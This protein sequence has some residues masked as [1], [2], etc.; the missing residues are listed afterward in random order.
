MKELL[1]SV[2]LHNQDF[3]FSLAIVSFGTLWNLAVISLHRLLPIQTVHKFTL[4]HK[5]DH[6]DLRDWNHAST[7]TSSL[8]T[9]TTVV[10]SNNL[11]CYKATCTHGKGECRG[12]VWWIFMNTAAE[13]QPATSK[14]KA[15]QHAVK[16]K[17]PWQLMPVLIRESMLCE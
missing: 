9:G 2:P 6:E 15:V 3:I 12:T 16:T 4:H 17:Q 11:V 7:Y 1:G 13:D 14:P 10:S 8:C 5:G